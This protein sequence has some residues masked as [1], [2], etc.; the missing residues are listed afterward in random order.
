MFLF[1]KYLM[2]SMNWRKKSALINRDTL[3]QITQQYSNQI[4]LF[5]DLEMYLGVKQIYLLILVNNGKK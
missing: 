2:S 3:V 5:D 4:K 1:S